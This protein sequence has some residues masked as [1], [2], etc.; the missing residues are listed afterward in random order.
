PHQLEHFHA[1]AL[2]GKARK[3]RAPG[4]AGEIAGAIRLAMAVGR[5]KA[6]EPEDAQ[7]IFGNALI[8]IADEAYPSG[9][10]II[11]PADMVM[12]DAIRVDGKAVDGEVAPLGIAHPV[13]AERHF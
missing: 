9:G 7:I 3:S 11:E 2:G 6:E 4:D 5:V 1:N 10:D 13:A 8:G 12:D